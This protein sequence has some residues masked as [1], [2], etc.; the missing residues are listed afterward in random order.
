MKKSCEDMYQKAGFG[1]SES[2]SAPVQENPQA[3]L[4]DLDTRLQ[5]VQEKQKFCAEKQS[6]L[7]CSM[8]AYSDTDGICY[9]DRACKTYCSKRWLEIVLKSQNRP[10]KVKLG[11]ERLEQCEQMYEKVRAHFGG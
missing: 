7:S 3:D 11:M 6:V 5:S 8:E 1:P 4:S 10:E 9:A 2:G